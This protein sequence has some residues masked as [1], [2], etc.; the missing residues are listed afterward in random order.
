VNSLTRPAVQL[1]V[2]RLDSWEPF[3][4]AL[5]ECL[6]QGYLS[7]GT[8]VLSHARGCHHLLTPTVPEKEQR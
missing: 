4:F 5:Q 3:R 6:A 2:Q 8:P 7:T 1:T